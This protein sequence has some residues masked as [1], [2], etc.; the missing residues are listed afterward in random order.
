MARGGDNAAM[1]YKFK[2]AASGDLIM[3]AAHGDE[4]MR[5]LQREPA[6]RGIVE[7]D[8]MVQAI[9]LIKAAVAAAEAPRDN[10]KADADTDTDADTAA[11]AKVGLRQRLWPMLQML[12]RSLAGRVPIVWGV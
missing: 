11:P 10:A 12:E 7:V 3:L 9:A 2:S 5:V 6:A 4:L 1:L 8:A